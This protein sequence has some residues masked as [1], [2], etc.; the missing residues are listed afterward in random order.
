MW[1]D[2]KRE[3]ELQPM[4]LHPHPLEFHLYYDI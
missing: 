3:H 2:Y 1:L 4:R